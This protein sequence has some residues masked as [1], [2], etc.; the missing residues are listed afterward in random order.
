MT[1]ATLLAALSITASAVLVGFAGGV[2]AQTTEATPEPEETVPVVKSYDGIQTILLDND[3][4]SFRLGITGGRVEDLEAYARCA[5]AQYAQIR[6]Y[7]YA[8]HIRTNVV[9]NMN[10]W[11]GDAVFMI[12]ADLPRGIKV[13][14]AGET[15]A[16]CRKLEIPTV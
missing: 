12:S 4:V 10:R 16:E 15:L 9:R 6:G 5:V 13:I 2:A 8:R 3:L 7:G 1:S 11:N 14:T